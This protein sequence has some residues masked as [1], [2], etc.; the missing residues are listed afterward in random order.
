M[1]LRRS[2]TV[3]AAVVV[4][5]VA[6][7]PAAF[8]E[9]PSPTPS[10]ALP[11]GLYGKADPSFDG[12][13]RQSLALLAQD[14]VGVRPAEK[15]VDWLTG[16]QCADGA[17]APFRAEPSTACDAKTPVDTNSTAA[18]VQ[19]L[20]A[21]G[22]HKK[23]TDKAVDWLRSVQNPDGGWG[24]LPK[25]ASDTNSTSLVIGALNAAGHSAGSV[26]KG[27]KSPF[28]ALDSL[29]LPCAGKDG[30]AFAF[31]PDKPG[32]GDKGTAGKPKLTANPDA[33]AA[34]VLG[35]LGTTLAATEGK[36]AAEDTCVE[37]G[38][39]TPEQSAVAAAKYLRG[40]L[41]GGTH[42]MS[43]MPG[44][45]D[46]PDFG[47]TADT[48][49]ALSAA[50]DEAAAE[51]ALAWLEKNSA[52]WAEQ[53]GP[54]AFA[55]LVL[56]ARA[57][58]SDPRAFGTTDLVAELNSQGPAPQSQG[59]GGSDADKK[60]DAKKKD[61]SDDEGGSEVWWIVGAGLV[62]GIGVGFLF[63]GRNKKPRK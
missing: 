23:V 12:V 55:Q 28:D 60:D 15:A 59:A 37:P 30:G 38:K 43:A 16:Q 50:G 4:T 11:S 6:G 19:A 3:L 17:F 51:K 1:N 31:Q 2:V 32:K 53:S 5:G 8:A 14:S 29:T 48:V 35:S 63:S 46:K 7:A 34:A 57:T 58:G 9:S 13:W 39:A 61:D 22:G 21:L 44:A 42:L 47:N 20:A 40:A 54:A 18:A 45:E 56:A 62:A 10:V 33:S 27:G 36:A 26:K 41:N 49:V 25:G 24:Y 52:D